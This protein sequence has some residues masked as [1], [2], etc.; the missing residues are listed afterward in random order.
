[1]P[2]V[3]LQCMIVVFPGHILLI[4][5]SAFGWSVVYDCGIS[6]SYSLNFSWCLGL[7]C[8]V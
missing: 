4:F 3:G 7:V 1:M 5:Y 8:S 6:W 2:L